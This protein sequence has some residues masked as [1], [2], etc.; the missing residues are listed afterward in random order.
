MRKKR[1]SYNTPCT[2]FKVIA[3]TL[4]IPYG[5]AFS[6]Y[7]RGMAILKSDPIAMDGLLEMVKERS[8]IH[9]GS[10]ECDKG[11][12]EKFSISN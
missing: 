7:R 3:A 6:D 10:L 11:Y 5:T 1:G 8:L 2:S 12:I 4:G 9:A